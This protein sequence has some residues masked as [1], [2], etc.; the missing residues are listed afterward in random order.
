MRKLDIRTG[1][2][3]SLDFEDMRIAKIINQEIE[4]TAHQKFTEEMQVNVDTK[5]LPD[6]IFEDSEKQEEKEEKKEGFKG[7]LPDDV[8]R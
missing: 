2:K 1:L 5:K 3:S 8:I 4:K 6:N 7:S